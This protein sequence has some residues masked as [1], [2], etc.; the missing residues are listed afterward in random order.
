MGH[1]YDP[2]SGF[3][4]G[5]LFFFFNLLA[6]WPDVRDVAV[7]DHG[8]AMFFADI[9]RIGAKIFFP[10]PFFGRHNNPAVQNVGQF[11][12]VMPVGSGDDDGERDAT[13]FDQKVAL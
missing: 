7:I 2:S 3:V 12:N 9:T 13:L 1:L 11:G 5:V 8:L 6:P 4:F 10:L